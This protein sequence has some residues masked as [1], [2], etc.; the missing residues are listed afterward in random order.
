MASFMS[1]PL[2]I[3]MEIY[4]LC[5]VSDQMICPYVS[6]NEKSYGHR[7]YSEW[8]LEEKL[9]LGLLGVS[10]TIHNEASIVFYGDNTWCISNLFLENEEFWERH[11]QFMRHIEVG[12][13]QGD[14]IVNESIV[15]RGRAFT[16]PPSERTSRDIDIMA[17]WHDRFLWMQ[18][19]IW[20]E[21][22][23]TIEKMN[24]ASLKIDLGNCFCPTLC[25]R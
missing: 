23:D 11:I 9:D 18:L 25:C 6:I 20:R 2:E 3:C 1:L 17:G 15:P 7:V 4:K 24:L 14:P 16:Q 22:I 21:K 10:K 12:F 5:L 19:D 8:S 13:H